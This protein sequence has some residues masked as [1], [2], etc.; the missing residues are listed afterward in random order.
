MSLPR[1][2]S[3]DEWLV[4]RKEL[5][6]EEKALTRARD[7]L[8]AQ[9]RRL[10]IVEIEIEIEIEKD[11]LFEGPEG[12][13]SLLASGRARAGPSPGTR[14]TAASSTTTST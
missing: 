5:L 3:Q 7:A 11:Y 14:R 1:V 9:R 8:S 4:A 2:V 6:A 13:A 10:P 12:E